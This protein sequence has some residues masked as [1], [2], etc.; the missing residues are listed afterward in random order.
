M[1]IFKQIEAKKLRIFTRR[2]TLAI[3]AALLT[4]VGSVTALPGR[5][6]W[7]AAVDVCAPNVAQ[8]LNELKH[9]GEALG[10]HRGNSPDPTNSKHYQS[11]QRL[12][13]AGTPTF[14]VS[15]SRSESGAL[16]VMQLK[17]RPT[18]GE[19]V[20]S[21]K[22]QK[23]VRTPSTVPPTND[24]VVRTISFN[25][26]FLNGARLPRYSH[27]G[28]MQLVGDTLAVALEGP[29]TGE[30]ADGMIVLFDVSN[31]LSPVILRKIA[32]PH[33]AGGVALSR[34]GSG[35]LMLVI[36]PDFNRTLR[37][38]VSDRADLS[39]L[40]NA[41]RFI[42]LWS[43]T[44]LTN[45]LVWPL[46]PIGMQTINLI[47]QCNSQLFLLGNWNS[48][49]IPGLGPDYMSLFEVRL[50]GSP[51]KLVL[52]FIRQRHLFCDSEAGVI[53]DMLA[54][55]GVYVSPLGE[56][57][58]YG[59]EHDNDGPSGTIRMGEFRHRDTFR[60]GSAA[61]LPTVDALGPYEVRVGSSITLSAQTSSALIRPWVELYDDKGFSDRSVVLDY[62]D[63]LR[64]DWHDLDALEG[65]GDKASSVRWEAPVGC[66]IELW[67]NQNFS[68]S[69]K[70]LSGNGSVQSI[71]DLHDHGFGDDIHSVRFVGSCSAPL[72]LYSWDLDGNSTFETVGRA[73]TFA[74]PFT[75]TPGNY[76]VRVRACFANICV[77]DS[78]VVKITP[79]IFTTQ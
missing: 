41:F 69:R 6:A 59:T 11:I 63:R 28:G 9:H 22:L 52:T 38:Y 76:I 65:F 46:G 30:S 77:T 26:T 74:A 13:S 23:G 67:K 75:A 4:T 16:L 78:A 32:L 3:V 50:T 34:Y 31:P 8:Q 62:P 5:P 79:F 61:R 53:C 2:S 33:K 66:N 40:S 10:F 20:R 57:L 72:P 54:A 39:D 19:R 47:R 12:S 71:S 51:Q 43:S 68:G 44:E 56:L 14:F 48:N 49:P 36:G 24:S 58:V 35:W 37:A 1:N 18:Q 21:N 55:G 45:P 29:M 17:S 42:D 15:L 64:D 60:A 25:G 73:V 7:A 70:V 27:V